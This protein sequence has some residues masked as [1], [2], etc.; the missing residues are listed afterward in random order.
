VKNP[1]HES[2][3]SAL[4]GFLQIERTLQVRTLSWTSTD[5]AIGICQQQTKQILET[6][7]LAAP[8]L[9]TDAQRNHARA[10]HRPTLSQT[11]GN[12]ECSHALYE[13]VGG[14]KCQYGFGKCDC[15]EF[16]P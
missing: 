2:L 9:E 7:K 1:L 13:H 8:E 11:C 16:V 12:L 5:Q 6:F 3:A 14:S 4:D 15:Q 10:N